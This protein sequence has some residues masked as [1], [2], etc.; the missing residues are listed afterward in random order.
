MRTT[1]AIH[2]RLWVVP[3]VIFF[4]PIIAMYFAV[5]QLT[6]GNFTYTLDDPYIHLALAKNIWL[7]NYG[8]NLSEASAPSSS[9]IWPFLMAPFAVF[10][11]LFEYVPLI[12]NTFCVVLFGLL[13]LS[14]FSELRPIAAISFSLVLMLSLNVYGLAFTGMEHSAQVLLVLIIAW[15]LVKAEARKENAWNKF[16][17]YS[18]LILLPLVRYEGLAISLPVLIYLFIVEER[19]FPAFSFIFL[20]AGIVSFSIY[21]NSKGLGFLPSSVLA[22]SSHADSTSTL[23]NLIS[24]IK[25]HGFLLI[26]IFSICIIRFKEDKPFSL[27]LICVTALHFLFGKHGWYGRYEVYYI[28]FILVISLKLFL[29][30]EP[31]LW[32]V[33]FT[34]PFVFPDLVYAT[35]TTPLA[36]SNIFNQQAKMAA[37]TKILDD[38]VA[39]NDLG[40]VALRSKNYVLDL[41]GLGS[42]DA[43]NNRKIGGSIDWISKLMEKKDVKYA[44]I[45]DSWFPQR[46]HNWIK[47]AD[48]KLLQKRITPASD[49]VAFYA[50]SDE[51]VIKLRKVIDAFL[52][53][54]ASESYRFEFVSH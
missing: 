4:A 13:L 38:K 29:R 28:L 51:G 42:I 34:L 33:V 30:F 7:G 16:L 24:N 54:N 8:I 26:P 39:V 19:R 37:I 1:K 18:S 23:Q 11:N 45:Y 31:K 40:L 9:I 50:T 5:L 44:I 32:L 14:I 17:F 20:L 21:L 3:I 47:V 25:K 22:K 15:G 48:L 6:K 27:M 12:T 36:S 43:L 46:P 10:Q 53:E 49:S 35:V 52:Q 41:A 2:D